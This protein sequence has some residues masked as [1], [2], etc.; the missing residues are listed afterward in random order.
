MDS[1]RC[2][3]ANVAFRIWAS[4]SS[5]TRFFRPAYSPCFSAFLL[6]FGAPVIFRLHVP[7]R[8]WRAPSQFGPAH[9]A[10]RKPVI[11]P[12]EPLSLLG[13]DVV[14]DEPD[15]IACAS[16]VSMCHGPCSCWRASRHR[17]VHG[18]IGQP[19]Q[20]V[21]APAAPGPRPHERLEIF[22]LS[23]SSQPPAHLP[24]G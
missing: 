19:G 5:S 22:R 6:P 3:M 2:T 14:A 12:D 24:D 4:F 7:L 16:V 17:A 21:H 9:S 8:F 23:R 18:P 13:A 11:E 15:R 10:V 20:V 1:C